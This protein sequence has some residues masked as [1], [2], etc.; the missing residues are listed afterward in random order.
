MTLSASTHLH[1]GHI[2]MRVAAKLEAF[3]ASLAADEQE[4]FALALHRAASETAG[5]AWDTSGYA[6]VSYGHI[7]AR[8]YE[9]LVTTDWALGRR[10]PS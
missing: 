7:F 8:L 9:I 6:V 2:G 4:A 10:F 5:Q 1:G 3:S